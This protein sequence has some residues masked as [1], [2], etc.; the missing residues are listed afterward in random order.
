MP[1][2]YYLQNTKTAMV[3]YNEMIQIPS[4][5]TLGSFSSSNYASGLMMM[6]DEKDG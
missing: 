4:G 6:T 5:L 1:F 2:N 3:F